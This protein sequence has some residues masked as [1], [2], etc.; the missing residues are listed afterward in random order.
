MMMMMSAEMHRRALQSQLYLHNATRAAWQVMKASI[1]LACKGCCRRVATERGSCR[2][3]LSPD[4]AITSYPQ[5]YS[6]HNMNMNMTSPQS[7][8]HCHITYQRLACCDDIVGS[9]HALFKAPTA[10]RFSPI[11]ADLQ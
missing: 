4:W 5:Q 3:T 8:N 9:F 10:N 1:E 6:N 11:A 2:G 7:G